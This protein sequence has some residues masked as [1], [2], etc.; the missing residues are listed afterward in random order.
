IAAARPGAYDVVKLLLDRKANPS[1]VVNT[2]R[3]PVTPL[4][5]A[6]EV[7]DE[8]VLRLLL[9]R[10]ADAKAMGGVFPLL[11]AMNANDPGCVTLALKTAD[12]GAL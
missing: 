8:A 11:A 1:S 5:L 6:A 7:G 3:G 4:R 12:R 9:D 2:Y 10:G